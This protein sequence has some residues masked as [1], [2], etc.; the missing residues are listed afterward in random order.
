MGRI[1]NPVPFLHQHSNP[2]HQ[3][4]AGLE[5]SSDVG[6]YHRTEQDIIKEAMKSHLYYAVKKGLYGPLS[7][8]L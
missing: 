3:S 7:R 4:K 6:S 8:M 5:T 1:H 2:G